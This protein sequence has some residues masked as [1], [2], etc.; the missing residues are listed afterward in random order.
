MPPL[1]VGNLNF[2]ALI[3][4]DLNIAD[5]TM[6]ELNHAALALRDRHWNDTVP[7]KM[8][9]MLQFRFLQSK[10]HKPINTRQQTSG[11]YTKKRK[12]LDSY[13]LW[14]YLGLKQKKAVAIKVSRS[15]SLTI[16]MTRFW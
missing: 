13:Y 5:L 14:N 6:R 3:V 15:T 8:V 1:I 7:Q 12:N 16:K 4:R 9:T 11:T 10:I 2:A